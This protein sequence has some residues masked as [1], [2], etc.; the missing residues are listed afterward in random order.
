MKAGGDQGALPNPTIWRISTL[1]IPVLLTD[2]RDLVDPQH[3][4]GRGLTPTSPP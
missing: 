1:E 3:L 4:K 2:P